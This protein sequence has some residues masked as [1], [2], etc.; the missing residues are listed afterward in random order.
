[1]SSPTNG[2]ICYIE[3]PTTDIAR[4]AAFYSKTFGWNIRMRGNGSPPL[5]IQPDR[6]AAPGYSGAR[7]PLRPA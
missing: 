7:L 4:S 2:K 3:M 6:S 5:T 1:M